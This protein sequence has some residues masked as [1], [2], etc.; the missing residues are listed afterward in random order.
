MLRLLRTSLQDCFASRQPLS[1][2]VSAGIVGSALQ[3]STL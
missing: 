2:R 3:A 1:I